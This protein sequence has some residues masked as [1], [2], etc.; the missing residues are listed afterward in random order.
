MGAWATKSMVEGRWGAMEAQHDG[1][2]AG[3]SPSRRESRAQMN[4]SL[5]TSRVLWSSSL[6]SKSVLLYGKSYYIPPPWGRPGD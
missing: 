2:T 1:R 6:L 4:P 3:T 5:M